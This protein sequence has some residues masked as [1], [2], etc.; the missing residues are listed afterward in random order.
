[1][2]PQESLSPAALT[3]TCPPPLSKTSVTLPCHPPA[4]FL[5]FPAP[6]VFRYSISTGA[7]RLL[8]T[9]RCSRR[10]E[11]RKVARGFRCGTTLSEQRHRRFCEHLNEIPNEE[12][13]VRYDSQM[14]GF[15]SIAV[16]HRGTRDEQHPM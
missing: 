13:H 5:R 14:R 3:Q 11:G 12:N 9:P 15:N 2:I 1:M 10:L 6:R 8:P 4:D 16:P 7:A